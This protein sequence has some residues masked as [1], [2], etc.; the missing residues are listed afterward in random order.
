MH[1][2][3]SAALAG[4]VSL[5]G[6][7]KAQAQDFRAPWGGHDWRGSSV[8][9]EDFHAFSGLD[10]SCSDL[11]PGQVTEPLWRAASSDIITYLSQVMQQ[12]RVCSAPLHPG[13]S[14]AITRLV[15]LFSATVMG[16]AVI[17]PGKCGDRKA[18]KGN[19]QPTFLWYLT[20]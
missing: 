19:P 1:L 18:R 9:V 16:Q 10:H 12:S 6:E 13:W 4:Q 15:G 5:E 7:A 2:G 11:P 14:C 3:A 17:S 8:R 20:L